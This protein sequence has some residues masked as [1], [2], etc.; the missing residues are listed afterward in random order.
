MKNRWIAFLLVLAM[1]FTGIP[2]YSEETGAEDMTVVQA[3]PVVTPES[4]EE[5]ALEE[6]AEEEEIPDS[7]ADENTPGETEEG[8]ESEENA[9]DASDASFAVLLSSQEESTGENTGVE[10]VEENEAETGENSEE[11][12]PEDENAIDQPE[13]ENEEA[14]DGALEETQDE[15]DPA[16]ND[17]AEPAAPEEIKAST[18]DEAEP[19]G[20][21]EAADATQGVAEPEAS[22]EAEPETPDEAESATPDEAEPATP[23][24]ADAIDYTKYASENPSFES[25]YAMADAYA[26]LFDS[27]NASDAFGAFSETG[28]VLALTREKTETNTDRLKIAYASEGGVLTA[29]ISADDIRPMSEEEI[30]RYFSEDGANAQNAY[31]FNGEDYPLAEIALSLNETGA[32]EN[33]GE[34]AGI[35]EDETAAP[36]DTK[37]DQDEGTE[38]EADAVGSKAA[39]IT[40]KP[41]VR[42]EIK[43][44]PGAIGVGEEIQLASLAY[45]EDGNPVEGVEAEY[46][47]K[48]PDIAEVDE[49]GLVTGKDMGVA[50]ITANAEGLEE[51]EISVQVLNAPVSMEFAESAVIIGEGASHT[52]TFSFNEGS[53]GSVEWISGNEEI[54][55][56][57]ENGV[58]QAVGLGAAAVQVRAYNGISAACAVTVMAEPKD[59]VLTADALTLNEGESAVLG[60]SF[61]GD[62]YGLVEYFLKDGGDEAEITELGDNRVEITGVRYGSAVIEARVYNHKDETYYTAECA[63][64]VI[65]APVSIQFKNERRTVGL[66]ERMSLEPVAYNGRGEEI[67]TV[68]TYATSNKSY[69][70]VNEEGV[71]G[72]KKGSANIKVTA[73]NG[74]ESEIVRIQTV[75]APT[76]VTIDAHESRLLAGGTLALT[77]SLP[78]GQ[79]GAVTWFSEDEETAA[80]NAETG[81]VTGVKV[82]STRI[83][84]QTY[85]GEYALTTVIVTVPPTAIAFTEAVYT[86]NEGEEIRPVLMMAPEGSYAEVEYTISDNDDQYEIASVSADGTVTGVTSGSAVVTAAAVNSETGEV[87]SAT[88]EITVIPAPK[89]VVLTN[90]RRT[91]GL[92]ERMSLEPVAYDARGNIVDTEFTYE[93]SSSRYVSVNANG[94]YGAK[95]GSANVRV[96]ASN[97]VE[98]EIV[99]LTVVYAPKEITISDTSAMLRVGDTMSLSATIPSGQAGAVQWI[100]EYEEIA[101]VDSKTGLVTILDVGEVRIKCETYNGK[102]AICT[103]TCTVPPTGIAFEKA[104]YEVSEREQ[105]SPVALLSPNGAYAEI[106]YSIS[107]DDPEYVIATVDTNGTVKGVTSGKATLTASAY[108]EE[109]DS[110]V[111]AD[112]EIIVVPAPASIRFENERR[113]I[114]LKERMSLAPAAYDARGNRVETTFTYATSN[115][116]Y[117]TVNEDGAYGVK[118]GSANVKVTAANGVESE[119]VKITVVSAPTKVTISQTS[120]MLRAGSTISLSASLPSGQVGAI[121]WISQYEDI[122]SV[123]PVTGVVTARKAGEVQIKAEAYNGKSAVCTLTV[124]VPPDVIVFDK[125]EY[126]VFEG[127]TIQTNA[128]L[129][130]VGAHAEIQ[131]VIGDSDDEYEIASVDENGV[132]T[133]LVSGRALLTASAYNE[134]TGETVYATCAVNVHPAPAK[135]VL[136][137]ERRE[138]GLY[139]RMSLEPV[140]YDARGNEVETSFTYATS[141]KS[142]VSVN[143]SGVYGARKGSAK[144]KVTAENGVESEIISIKTVTAPSKV[145]LDRTEAIMQ[146]G[147]KLMLNASLPSGQAGAITYLSSDEQKASVNALTGEITALSVGTVQIKA[148]T[149]N[150]KSAVLA[151]TVTVPPTGISFAESVYVLD[152]G[153]QLNTN[154][155]LSPAGSY[156]VVHYEIMDND[157]DT[158]ASVDENGVITGIAAGQAQ[159]KATVY[160]EENH[161]SLTAVADITVQQAIVRVELLNERRSIGLKERMSL[162]PVAY[163]GRGNVV[164][165]VF[166][167]KSSSTRYVSVNEEGV[168]GA[169]RGSANIQVLS[170]NG[171]A[172]EIVKITTVYAP[173]KVSVSA[174]YNRMAVGDSMQLTAS[175]PSGQ[176]GSVK[177]YSENAEFASVDEIT[178]EVTA[179]SIGQAV[180]K[181][182][183]YNGKIARYTI[184]VTHAPEEISFASA[185]YTVYEGENIATE[186]VMAPQDSFAIVSYDV[187]DEDDE[188]LIASV[189]DEGRVYGLVSGNAVLTASVYNAELD[190]TITCEADIIVLPAPV[191]VEIRN[192]RRSVGLKERMSLDPVAYDARGNE[193]ET[194]FTY[195]TSKKSYVSV[196]AEGVYGVKKGSANIQIA[197]ANGAVS[198]IVKITTVTAPSKVTL[199]VT[200][201]MLRK[202]DSIQLTASIPSG[203]AGAIEW[204]SDNELVAKVDPVTGLVQALSVGEVRIMARA[205]NGKNAVCKL[206]VTVPPTE[207]AFETDAYEVYERESI[208]PAVILGPE[209]AYSEIEYEIAYT[210]DVY[211]IAAVSEDGVVTG[212]TSGS[213]VV[214]AKA[215][216]E[217]T[218]ET[219]SASCEITVLPAPNSIGFKNERRTVGLKERM[220]LEPV[221]YDVR[222]NEVETTFTYKTSKKSYV[223]VNAEGVYGAKKGSAN[224]QVT[225]AN[226][227]L[228]EIVKITT[229]SAPTRVTLSA[230]DVMLRVGGNHQLTAS[231]PSGQA[232]AIEWISDNPMIASVDPETGFVNA[233]A[234][235]EAQIMA[236]AYNGKYAVCRLTVTVPPTEIAFEQEAYE[237]SEK[238]AIAPKVVLGPEGAYS[239]IQY[240]IAYTDEEYVIAS[241]SEDGVVSGITSGTAVLT[242]SAYNEETGETISASCEIDVLPAPN[243]I[244]F[245]NERRRVG[246]KERMSLEPQAYDVR[247]NEVETTFTYKSGSTRYVTVNNEGVYGARTGSAYVTVTSANGIVSDSVRITVTNAPAKITLNTTNEMLRVGDSIQL[248][249]V[250]GSERAGA[251]IWT[252]EYPEIASVDPGTGVVTA[253]GTGT[254]MIKAETYNGIKAICTIACT[255]PPTGVEFEETEITLYEGETFQ[256]KV[257][258]SPEGA[259]AEVVYAAIDEDNEFEIAEVDE[260]GVIKAAVSGT[261][262]VTA[263][264]YNEDT[265]TEYTA[266]MRVTVLPAPVRVV[267]LNGRRSVGLSERMDLEPIAY[268]GRGNIIETTFTYKSSKTAYV[269]V[270]S[271]GVY[272]R[273][274]GSANIQVIAANGASSEI[275]KITT[276]A[277]PNKVSLNITSHT[278]SLTGSVQLTPVFPSGQAGSVTWSSGDEAV[279]KVDGNGMVTAV[280]YGDTLITVK[281]HNGRTASCKLAVRNEPSAVFFEVETS[282]VGESGTK[283]VPAAIPDGCAGQITYSSSNPYVATVNSVT[284][285]VTGVRQGNA[286]IVA[287]VVNNLT[288]QTYTDSYI[289]T[290]TPAPASI[291]ITEERRK[292]G[293][294]E[295]LQLNA[296]ALDEFG[297]ETEGSFTYSSNRTRYATVDNKGNVT[298]KATGY[299]NITVRTYNGL[300]VTGRINVVKA[301]A[302]VRVNKTSAVISEVDT[303][304]LLSTLSSGSVGAVTWSSGN[305]EAAVVDPETGLVTAKAFGE[306][307][308]TVTTY[309]GKTASCLVTVK[310]EP[311]SVA[312]A[313]D[314]AIIG[315]GAS[316]IIAAS[317]PEECF[318]PII[319]QSD[320]P[321]IASVDPL[322]GRVTGVKMGS[323]TITATV[324]NRTHSPSQFHTDTYEITVTP[325]PVSVVMNL[326]RTKVGVNEIMALNPVAL[327][328]E[329]NITDGGFTFATSNRS[330]VKVNENGEVLGVRKGSATITIRTYNGVSIQGKITVVSAPS[331]IKLNASQARISEIGSVRL[332]A[333]LGGGGVGAITWESSNENAATVD[334][335]G[336]VTAKGFG[337][338]TITVTSY[339]GKVAMCEVIVLKEPESVTFTGE[340]TS[341]GEGAKTQLTAT[342]GDDYIGEIVYTSMDETIATVDAATGVVTGV[343]SGEVTIVATAR[344]NKENYEVTDECLFT[345]TPAP[346]RVEILNTRTRIGY[347][348]TVEIKAV[349]YDARGNV[350]DGQLKL[351]SSNTRKVQ[352]KDGMNIYAYGTGSATIG[353]V[354]YNGVFATVSITVVNAPT[355]VKLNVSNIDLII[356]NEPVQLYTSI[357]SGTAATFTWEVEDDTILSVDQEGVLTPLAYGTTRVKAAAHNG[358]YALCTVNVFEAPTSVTLNHHQMEVG[359]GEVQTL[360]HT[361][362]ERS[363][364]TVSWK[365]SDDSTVSV[366][367]NG[368]FM[369]HKTGA[370]DITVTTYNGK[371]D[372]CRVMVYP[373][374]ARDDI[375]L[376]MTSIT[377]GVGQTFDMSEIVELSGSV[378]TML[379][380]V[381]EYSSIASVNSSTGVITA[382]KAGTGR[383]AVD[384]HNGIRLLL[385]VSV[386]AAPS[387]VTI[388]ADKPI[389]YIGESAILTVTLPNNVYA[390]VLVTSSDENVCSVGEDMRTLTAKGIGKATITVKTYNGKTASGVIEVRQHVESIELDK[391]EISI[392]HYDETTLQAIVLPETAYDRSVTWSSSAPE[393]VS[394]DQNGKI[395][396]LNVTDSPVTITAVTNDSRNLTASCLV[397][398]TPVRVEGIELSKTAFELEK[399]REKKLEVIF[400]PANADDKGIIW[401]SSNESV[402]SVTDGVV[403]A[404]THEGSAVITATS[405][406]GGFTASCEVTATRILIQ[407]L[408]LV[409]EEYDIVHYDTAA[410]AAVLSP[411]DAEYKSMIWASTDPET[412]FVDWS[413]G[414]EA[415]KVGSAE[416]SVKVE[417]YFGNTY[418]AI[419]KVNVTPVRVEGVELTKETLQLRVGASGTVQAVIAPANA[420]DMLVTWTSSNNNIVTVREDDDDTTVNTAVITAGNTPGQA[421]VT[422]KTNDGA[423]TDVIAVTVLDALRIKANANHHQNNVGNDVVWMFAPE[424]VVGEA[425]YSYEVRKDGEIILSSGGFTSQTFAAV[426]DAEKGEYVIALSLKDSTG[427]IVQTE[428]TVLVDDVIT[429][430]NGNETYSYVIYEGGEGSEDTVAI[431]LHSYADMPVNVTLPKD[432]HGM[433]IVRID[434]EAFIDC[435]KLVSLS[436]PK[437]VKTVGARAFKGCTVFTTLTGFEVE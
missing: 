122:A 1:L 229:S 313:E 106:E 76:K 101:H 400:T 151:L 72:V 352:I 254:V 138:I 140:A 375:S 141:N 77:A 272:G 180:I 240:S 167:Y 389:L 36:E 184:N 226:G 103:I 305:T 250:I 282:K 149:Y 409:S 35:T 224:I 433:A 271:E 92:Y 144:I 159:L 216:N 435:N 327:D 69:V 63:L 252:S 147:E 43:A 125:A 177:W 426:E 100:S 306:A 317:I 178:G 173:S 87:L 34:N 338:T 394:V 266:D 195:K 148:Q 75:S 198:E 265:E 16:V 88:T 33:D 287:T 18:P 70:S 332:K 280:G 201:G 78:S 380:Y 434:T 245:K 175:V 37:A 49:N 3:E 93:T 356:G 121:K 312:F 193:I 259:Y 127:E 146:V 397:T 334:Q 349:T 362:S 5:A 192:E 376:T 339:N 209:G 194:V 251:I 68:F 59:I 214:T 55:T 307:V 413:G 325:A 297:E 157:D 407:E 31:A 186:I 45:D 10:A 347:R 117:I 436:I 363:A 314:T 335:S 410:F 200:E 293:V 267:L 44:L 118:K 30:A 291:V 158:I 309:N 183:T 145:T 423:F 98:S 384:T 298:G 358:R 57:D 64:E 52:L 54:I 109:T 150:G 345:V 13:N 387:K 371:K 217:D 62:A 41:A 99:K 315:E 172:S 21:D 392:V 418:T 162:E 168:Y 269:T 386:K 108:N 257:L 401:T 367:K 185:Q 204:L 42:I 432:I 179:L 302:S 9:E 203:Q 220:S 419:C 373:A 237:V 288:G 348:E 60:A 239:E 323:C 328:A 391:T 263:T 388:S 374:P 210:D 364:G 80:V 40:V 56:V 7:S 160:D 136:T 212:I 412:V 23:D 361:L 357:N 107:Y 369:A 206:T 4:G 154:L 20:S 284:G 238:A 94:A 219:I 326:E 91:I 142:Y 393:L 32:E 273:A 139:E 39:E 276:V 104:S 6:A 231:I 129:G 253:I 25:G 188:Y 28:V 416:I 342:L 365:S 390:D 113:S 130:P 166:T 247:G 182:E 191:T 133:G 38:P 102:S 324:E 234:T 230:T 321:D 135:V 205:Y 61:T 137:C 385:S 244:S 351:Q 420:D 383:I 355:T 208:L 227:V 174:M 246:L 330:Y 294:N 295:V 275:V 233:L 222:G 225:A 408:T 289:L 2:V 310:Y 164:D 360:I 411:A 264:V 17:E 299:S 116:R 202:G 8:V 366:D 124:T 163:D 97:G 243:S 343:K 114:G 422:V 50:V 218:E 427:E 341:V 331:S 26:E 396:A 377:L 111:S 319:Y 337:N 79:D 153:K 406:D 232:G 171:V 268:D 292:V 95:R 65:P 304:Q 235:G 199:D 255:V 169:N 381:H 261:A 283:T 290:V 382:K 132:V 47:T 207:I 249:A 71:Y 316:R 379:T 430:N 170:E 296:V 429:Y 196:N 346:A 46:A 215:Y 303:L 120:G 66:K 405:S 27:K 22:D 398:V 308:I 74:V 359:V 11:E 336:L 274:R 378:R 311:T 155:V 437:T 29:Y 189:D 424:N 322:T 152:E 353:A 262:L 318:G 112:C 431:K 425:Q 223:S 228:S 404:L 414:I 281:T 372:T 370:A 51:A 333:T 368:M 340:N 48:N 89:T 143:D 221:A 260:N 126:E 417:D 329:G 301:P 211:V 86:V 81:V 119:I 320:N 19:E 58:V 73:A 115:K 395:S 277:A 181:A 128:I 415:K 67:E 286:V 285:L 176:A 300:S 14:V 161:T 236:K 421:N 403:K 187:H 105:I 278:I 242:A 258:L 82:G 12:N 241:V 402:I 270:N 53:G 399:K 84:A 354:A 134:E 197:S 213:A 96:T 90:D 83:K 110:Y 350:I 256:T 85:N 248:T 15:S 344:N 123:D 165:T 156:A 279:A 24:E 131:Y 190:R 428:N